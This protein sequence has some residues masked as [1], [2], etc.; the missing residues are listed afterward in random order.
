MKLVQKDDW[1]P[2][3]RVWFSTYFDYATN[4]F[5]T[6]KTLQSAE[7]NYGMIYCDNYK[8]IGT[9]VFEEYA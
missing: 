4:W 3:K 8:V 6:N 9:Y 7:I 2:N 1:I 5:N